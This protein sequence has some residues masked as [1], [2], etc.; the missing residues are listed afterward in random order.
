MLVH[1]LLQGWI[2]K[3]GRKEINASYQVNFSLVEVPGLWQRRS[4]KQ[5]DVVWGCLP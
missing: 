4:L 2:A 5:K 1:F 3:V